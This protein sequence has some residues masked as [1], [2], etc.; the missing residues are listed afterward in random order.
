MH[1]YETKLQDNMNCRIT[2]QHACIRPRLRDGP[3]RSPADA[4][5]PHRQALFRVSWRG[6]S[7]RR[8]N[9]RQRRSTRYLRA[10]RAIA[11]VSGC[12]YR[13]QVTNRAW[14]IGGPHNLDARHRQY[15]LACHVAHDK[16]ER[17][18]A[19]HPLVGGDACPERNLMM[20]AAGRV[21]KRCGCLNPDT[22]TMG[23]P[24]SSVVPD[25]ARELVR[26]N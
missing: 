14:P 10:D 7:F 16:I 26:G 21:Y 13:S 25:R 24:L 5:S 22:T 2:L 8:K 4:C 19:V 9:R 15:G 20:S 12:G 3:S 1:R 11:C 17:I 23:N 6:G 18:A